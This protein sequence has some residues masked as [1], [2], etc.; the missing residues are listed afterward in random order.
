MVHSNYCSPCR[1]AELCESSDEEMETRDSTSPTS[2]SLPPRPPKHDLMMVEE[3][4][5]I[6]HT[7]LSAVIA[8]FLVLY[9][10]FMSD[11]PTFI[12][13]FTHV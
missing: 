1:E 12:L 6:L 5:D 9:V 4:R 11:T 7:V 13:S 8:H 2:P 10:L 3:V